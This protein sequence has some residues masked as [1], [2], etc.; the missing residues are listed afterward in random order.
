[1]KRLVLVGAGHAHARV[2]LEFALRRVPDL[3]IVLVSPA[4]QAPYSGMVPGWLAGHYRWDECCLDFAHLCR[5]AGA[6]LRINTASAIDPQ[7]QELVLATGETIAYDW[8]SLD[9]GSTLEPPDS[10]QTTVL[11]MRP[12]AALHDRWHALLDEVGNIQAG[13]SYRVLMVGGGAAG[14]ESMLAARERLTRLAPQVSFQFALATQGSSLVPGLAAGAARRLDAHLARLGITTVHGFSADH[15]Q[16][17]AVVSG[18]GQSLHADA[19]LWATGA[20][21]YTWPGESGL[22]TDARGFV[23]IDATLRSITHPNIFATGDCASWQPPL[24]K[25]GV[26]AVRMG[27][28]L[29]HNLRAAIGGHSLQRYEP[30]RRYLVLI[31][32][33]GPHAVATWG[34]LAWQGAWVWRWKHRIDRRFVTRYNTL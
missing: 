14:V 10:D 19:V 8:L 6:E 21:A 5:R 13:S 15:L 22:A 29:A 2:L 17:N 11:P 9:I 34:P 30:Q 24:P 16:H 1:V 28:V 26:Y 3:D 25:A 7:C 33:G 20:Q 4:P 23:L 32:T 12:L 31:G 18:N 27:P